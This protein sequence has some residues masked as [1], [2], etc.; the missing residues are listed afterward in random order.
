MSHNPNVVK[1]KGGG[2]GGTAG[3][4]LAIK[5]RSCLVCKEHCIEGEQHF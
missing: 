1:G 2:G 4:S 5:E 3:A